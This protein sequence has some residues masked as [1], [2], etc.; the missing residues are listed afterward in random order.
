MSDEPVVLINLLKVEPTK[1]EALIA[2]L[3]QNTD[4]VVS[5]L[6]GWKSTRLIAARDGTNIVIYSEWETPDAVV[7]MRDDPRMKAFFPKIL[8]L[9]SVDSFLGAAV[10]SKSR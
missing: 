2:L 8:A 7:T 9:A 6:A 4:T 3:K 5:T 1:Q 10:L